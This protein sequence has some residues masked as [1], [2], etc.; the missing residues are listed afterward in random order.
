MKSQILSSMKI[1]G[2]LTYSFALF[3]E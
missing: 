3:H 1:H 2:I